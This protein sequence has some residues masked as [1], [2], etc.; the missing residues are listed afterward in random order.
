MKQVPGNKQL[1]AGSDVADEA[2]EITKPQ[3][4][5]W[6]RLI[7]AGE[8]VQ[9]YGYFKQ[10]LSM[11]K[12]RSISRLARHLRMHRNSLLGYSSRFKWVDRAAAYDDYSSTKELERQR[13]Y[14]EKSELEWAG[15]RDEQRQ[16]EWDIAQQLLEKVRQMLQVPLFKETISERLADLDPDGKIIIEQIV[17]IEP[18]D[19]S[20]LDIARY[21]EIA[22]KVARLST[23]M[24][25]D[26]K[27]IRIDV[28]A[29]ADEELERLANE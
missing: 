4:R 27:R 22:S 21:F 28:T 10:F 12:P 17:S 3:D 14:R 5:A 2:I 26:Q 20:A 7:S 24:A 13:M 1:V 18:L 9:A 16:Q 23:G 11:D 29:M 6:Y 15:R 8:S 25:T 19:W